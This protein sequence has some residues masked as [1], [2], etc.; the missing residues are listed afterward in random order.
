MDS[1]GRSEEGRRMRRSVPL[2]A[3]I[4]TVSCHRAPPLLAQLGAGVDQLARAFDEDQSH[5]R[6]LVLASPT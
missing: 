5:P 1:G 2:L 4:A 3:L 6:L